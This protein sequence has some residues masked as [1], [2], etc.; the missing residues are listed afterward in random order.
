MDSG[1]D[2]YRSGVV[3]IGGDVCFGGCWSGFQIGVMSGRGGP[4]WFGILQPAVP[5]F[6]PWAW[7]R[8]P[9]VRKPGAPACVG[10]I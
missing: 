10:W 6:L 5:G 2:T 9:L 4:G 8:A 7:C 1:F 3:A